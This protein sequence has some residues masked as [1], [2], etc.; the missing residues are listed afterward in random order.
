MRLGNIANGGLVIIGS[1]YPY[2]PLRHQSGSISG[3]RKRGTPDLTTFLLITA[4]IGAF[5][6]DCIPIPN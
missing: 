3:G 5:G 4:S 6:S 1:L 2:R